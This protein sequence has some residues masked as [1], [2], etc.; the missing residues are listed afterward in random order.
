MG[1]IDTRWVHGGPYMGLIDTR[2]VHGGPYMG[3]IDTRW[4]Y[5]GPYIAGLICCPPP[6]WCPRPCGGSDGGSDGDHAWAAPPLAG[7]APGR[8]PAAQD[9]RANPGQG[10]SRLPP[11]PPLPI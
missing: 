7:P 6:V 10:Q 5:G 11:L 1:L 2:W 4:V 8:N 9:A 3:L